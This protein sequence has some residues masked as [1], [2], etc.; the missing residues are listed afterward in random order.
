MAPECHQKG[1]YTH[2]SDVY[3]FGILLWEMWTHSNC[4]FYDVQDD[5][6]VVKRYVL[7]LIT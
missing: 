6:K 4:P 5:E 3:A 7:M 1:R 2:K